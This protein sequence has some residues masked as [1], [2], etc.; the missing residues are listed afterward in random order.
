MR[1]LYDENAQ[2][3]FSE[4]LERVNCLENLFVNG[5]MV[6]KLI[7]GRDYL[8]GLELGPMLGSFEHPNKM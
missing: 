5:R 8:T 6:L 4:N 1:I 7:L 3:S 2:K